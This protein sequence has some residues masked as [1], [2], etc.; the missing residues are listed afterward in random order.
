MFPT[1]YHALSAPVQRVS[2]PHYTS[3]GSPLPGATSATDLLLK[4]VAQQALATEHI[5]L[6]V[7]PMRREH[8]SAIAEILEP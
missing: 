7:T 3:R 6:P 2:H 5:I 8:P 4:Q 1:A